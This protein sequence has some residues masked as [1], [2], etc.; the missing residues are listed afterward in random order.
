[1]GRVVEQAFK[2]DSS[3]KKVSMYQTGGMCAALAVERSAGGIILFA[4][5]SDSI[6]AA[7]SAWLWPSD[8]AYENGDEGKASGKDP[9]RQPE[10]AIEWLRGAL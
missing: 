6:G 1:L 3:L 10:S 2:G 4:D 9:F 7:F 5:A 8:E